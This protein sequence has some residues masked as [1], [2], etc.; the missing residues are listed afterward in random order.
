MYDERNRPNWDRLLGA[1]LHPTQVEVLSALEWIDEP[2]SATDL[3]RVF[4]RTPEVS[5]SGMDYHV[6]R[7]ATLGAL[8]LVSSRR[9]RGAT[10]YFYRLDR[11]WLGA[12]P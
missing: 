4:G 10:E 5:R 9:V 1:V 8:E 6:K 12:G 7:L 11:R 2:L 3:T